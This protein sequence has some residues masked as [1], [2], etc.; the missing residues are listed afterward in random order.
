MKK[1]FLQAEWR[2]L[3]MINYEVDPKIIQPFIP[4]HTQLDLYNGKCLIS[5]V[6][7]MFLNTKIKGF[8]I[9]MHVNFEEVNLRFYI[10]HKTQVGV[11]KRGTTFIKE[12]V[13]KRAITF[14]ANTLYNE[15]YVTRPMAHDINVSK[16]TLEV[17][18]KWNNDGKT[19]IIACKAA[20]KLQTIVAN[21]IEEFITEHYWGY[22]FISDT[23]TSEYAVEHPRWQCYPVTDIEIDV[24]FE[25]LYGN[26]FAHLKAQKPHSVILAEGSEILV[27]EGL[28]LFNAPNPSNFGLN[29]L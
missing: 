4:A 28:K 10:T 7:F 23:K 3:L 14:V 20:N 19:N 1:I 12:I 13:P 15:K 27:R 6:G 18:Y 26:D 2:K 25:K 11:I 16:E 21:S 22:T 17:S 8:K 24:D 5:I 29:C 9:P